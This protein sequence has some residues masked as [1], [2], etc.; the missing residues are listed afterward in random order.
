MKVLAMMCCT[1]IV[2]IMGWCSKET[3]RECKQILYRL[4]Q[5]LWLMLEIIIW[6]WG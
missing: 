6:V 4:L 1:A 3:Y 2:V 5:S